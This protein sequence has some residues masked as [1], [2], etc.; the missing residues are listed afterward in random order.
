M[1]LFER[2]SGK[3]VSTQDEIIRQ[4]NMA[5]AIAVELV[6]IL[7]RGLTRPAPYQFGPLGG[8]E[9]I[10]GLDA[11]EIRRDPETCLWKL[12]I[13]V[14]F[15]GGNHDDRLFRLEVGLEVASSSLALHLVGSRPQLREPISGPGD[16]ESI[17]SFASGIEQRLMQFVLDEA[18]ALSEGKKLPVWQVT[19]TPAPPA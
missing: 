15:P 13:S 8:N 9:T 2:I 4:R 1:S 3:V 11:L 7:N 16:G 14:L 12:P 17:G 10:T 5:Q 18:A 19:K 6:G